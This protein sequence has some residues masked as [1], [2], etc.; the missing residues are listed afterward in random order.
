MELDAD[1][2]RTTPLDKD[3]AAIP[4]GLVAKSIFNDTFQLYKQNDDGTKNLVDIIETGI[5]WSSDITYKFKNME[6]PTGSEKT[7][8][9]V[10]WLNMTDG[11]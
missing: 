6:M 10:Q 5:A 9:S 2:K 8:E 11:K 4:C 3:A 1:K 7:W